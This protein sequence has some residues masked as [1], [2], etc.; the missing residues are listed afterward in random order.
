MNAVFITGTDTGVG[1]TVVSRLL[2]RYLLDKGYKVIM[3]K[4]IQSGKRLDVKDASPYVAPYT[5]KFA[6][7]PHLAASLEGRRISVDKIKNSFKFLLNRFDFVIVE[8]IGGLLVPFNKKRLVIDIAEELNLPV[9]VVVG[10]RLG[11]I[12]HTLLTIEALKKRDMNII[13]IIFNNRYKEINKI[14]LKDNI[15]IIGKSTGAPILGSLPYMRNKNLLYKDFVPIGR[16]VFR[17]G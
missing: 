12:N 16:K 5:F 15:K 1:K 11:A 10:N 13:G 14:I 7:S 2:N 8:G 9:L 3:Q 6:S 17:H 4:W